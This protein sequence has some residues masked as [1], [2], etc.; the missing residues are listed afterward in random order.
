[1]IRPATPVLRRPRPAA[2]SIAAPVEPTEFV[3]DEFDIDGGQSTGIT[4]AADIT[5]T[6]DPDASA[7]IDDDDSVIVPAPDTSVFTPRPKIRSSAE[8]RARAAARRSLE[9]RRT[10]I[11]IL[12]TCAVV[13][14]GFASLKFIVGPDSTL[15]LTPTW[16]PV[17]LAAAAGILLALAVV[18]MISVKA[19]MHAL[20][21]P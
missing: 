21:E 18:N 13:M 4:G 7:I 3:P 11:P 14:L 16:A 10:L 5:G 12:L 6:A 9:F 20:K 8:T 15:T 2:P 1:V 17:L 19:N